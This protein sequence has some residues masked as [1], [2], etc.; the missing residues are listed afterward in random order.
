MLKSIW[1]VLNR[2]ADNQIVKSI[3]EEKMKFK[4]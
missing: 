4:L 2:N 3:I 1:E